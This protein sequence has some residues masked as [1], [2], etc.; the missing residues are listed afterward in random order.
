MYNSNSNLNFKHKHVKFKDWEQNLRPCD[1]ILFD[2]VDITGKCIQLCQSRKSNNLNKWVHIGIVCPHTFMDFKHKEK[3]ESYI[4]ESLFAIG[5]NT[6]NVE[7]NKLHGGLQIRKL[8]NVVESHINRG[9]S[10][11]CLRLNENP[12]HLTLGEEKLLT[13]KEKNI[14][15][16]SNL[17]IKQ[18]LNNFWKSYNHASYDFC[19]CSRSIGINIPFLKRKEHKRLFCSEAVIRLYQHLDIVDNTIESERI[20]PGKIAQWCLN[21]KKNK[22]E[23]IFDESNVSIISKKK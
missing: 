10:V 3:E 5:K 4:I 16:N 9:G 6:V 2:S 11:V 13:L 8:K 15:I 21:N 22:K 7:T 19:N 23:I 18:K 12:F 1:A 20:S 14:Y 17:V